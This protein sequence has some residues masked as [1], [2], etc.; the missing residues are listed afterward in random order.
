MEAQA[1][2]QWATEQRAMQQHLHAQQHMA[3]IVRWYGELL[4]IPL[5]D[6]WRTKHQALY[7]AVR[8]A[9]SEDTG[10]SA[11]AVQTFCEAIGNNAGYGLQAGVNRA[12]G[13]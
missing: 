2:G 13:R 12:I 5:D 3:R 8:D 1:E 7:T 9:L 11:E 4:A 10:V 6:P